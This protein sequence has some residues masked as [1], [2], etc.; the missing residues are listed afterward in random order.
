LVKLVMGRRLVAVSWQIV[1]D[2]ENGIQDDQKSK[3]PSN[4]KTGLLYLKQ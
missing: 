1:T 3:F 4:I 2:L